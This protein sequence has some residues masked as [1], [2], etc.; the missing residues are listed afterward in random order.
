MLF[1]TPVAVGPARVAEAQSPPTAPDRQA[2][3]D[4]AFQEMLRKPAD[5]DVLFRFATVASQTGDLEGAVSALE[6][7]LLINPNLPR[8]RLELGVLYYR[9]GSYEVARTYLDSVLAAPNLPPEVRA[10]TEQFM[11]QIKSAQKPSHFSGEVFGGLR[12]QSNAN[13]GPA[14]SSVLLFGQVANLNQQAVG[15]SGWGVVGSLQLRHVYDFGRQDRSALETQLTAYANREF[16]I[17]TADVSLL[18]FTSGPRFQILAD[19]FQDMTL[20]PFLAAGMIWVNDT[21]Y[22]PSYGSGLE[23]S[24]LLSDRLRDIFT[25]VWRRQDNYDTWYLP[26]NSQYRGLGLSAS[27]SAQF[28]LN[29]AITL[30]GNLGAQRFLAD[31]TAAQSYVLLGVGGGMAFTFPDPLFKSGLRWSVNLS[32]NEQWWTYDAPDITVDP[33]T[34]RYQQDTI[35]NLVLNVPFD[36]LT[37][38][39]V[40]VGRFVRASSVPNYA[41]TNNSLMFGLSRRF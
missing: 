21:P 24:T 13:L 16:Q 17:T 31:L 38:Y 41:F 11:A 7:M 18:D 34:M 25:V 29:S 22:Y 10:R 27:T 33:N 1:A 35:L 3:Y 36:D 39:S 12:Y 23:L 2:E 28:Q 5:L 9:L 14:N 40:S 26:T 37:T 20:K 8:V 4:A 6:R 15:A 32:A 19:T 30:F